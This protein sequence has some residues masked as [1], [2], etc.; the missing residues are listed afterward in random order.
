Q[1]RLPL[2]QVQKPAEQVPLSAPASHSPQS[3]G[4]SQLSVLTPHPA[5]P[6]QVTLVAWRTHCA[7][8]DTSELVL[9]AS[10]FMRLWRFFRLL[11]VSRG[12]R[13]PSEAA[14]NTTRAP[15]RV[16]GGRVLAMHRTGRGHAHT[17]HVAR[18]LLLRWL[19]PLDGNALQV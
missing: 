13:S 11:V 5:K 18:S 14:K 6:P 16:F 2:E 3:T 15:R 12:P 10:R 17:S 19:V 9:P 7:L 4:S 1:Q 8:G